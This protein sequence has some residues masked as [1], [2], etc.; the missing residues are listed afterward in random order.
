MEAVFLPHGA[1]GAD[2]Y[3]EYGHGDVLGDFDKGSQV[4]QLV[5]R[6]S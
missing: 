4:K 2:E 6:V 3:S 5:I 1:V